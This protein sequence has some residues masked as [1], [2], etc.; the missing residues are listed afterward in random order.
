M[1]TCTPHHATP[2][3]VRPQS[4]LT[5][6]R[7]V[8]FGNHGTMDSG[9]ITS[10][11]GQSSAL[12]LSHERRLLRALARGDRGAANQLVEATYG[13]VFAS[14]VRLCGGRRDMAAD[15]TQETYR[16]A[17][18]SLA[19]FDQR[20]RLSTW[21]YRIAYNTFLNHIRRP[22]RVELADEGG[23]PDVEDP[24]PDPAAQL[25]RLQTEERLRR[26]VLGLSEDLR[27]TVTARF[28]GELPVSEIAQLEGV[29]GAA[30]R[31]RLKK[32]MQGLR[33]SLGEG[34]A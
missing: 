22:M 25:D 28:W 21:L 14:L 6:G 31:K 33:H 11:A 7:S 10:S 15:L 34:S 3:A 32:A 20:S 19:R 23:L 27:F 29:S 4:G 30:I 17:W 18:T 12:E 5:P 16:K 26:A 9:S 1:T 2:F 13:M 24:R 8:S